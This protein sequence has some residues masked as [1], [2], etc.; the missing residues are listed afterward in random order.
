MED[1]VRAV[2]GR[3]GRGV[4]VLEYR[5]DEGHGRA[6]GEGGVPEAFAHRAVVFGDGPGDVAA[7]P[8]LVVELDS[9]GEGF[10]RGD[11]RLVEGTVLLPLALLV[12][13][14]REERLV[15]AGPCDR[16]LGRGRGGLLG[17]GRRCAREELAYGLFEVGERGGAGADGDGVEPVELGDGLGLGVERGV[18]LLPQVVLA[19]E[20]HV[21]AHARGVGADGHGVLAV[22]G[23][24]V[25]DQLAFGDV[26]VDALGLSADLANLVAGAPGH[27]VVR[28]GPL[29]VDLLLEDGVDLGG[30]AVPPELLG[31]EAG[32]VG[33]LTVDAGQDHRGRAGAAEAEVV[34]VGA[35]GVAR[36]PGRGRDDGGM[37]VRVQGEAD[38][39]VG[40]AYG[41][42]SPSV[43]GFG[44]RRPVRRRGARAAAR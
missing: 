32:V 12:E 33:L 3:E 43:M 37:V 21:P 35:G 23:M 14:G 40:G 42:G 38:V 30:E 7:V 41:I 22:V 9:Y 4:E 6:G 2:G 11:G 5:A 36:R 44:R 19:V 39:G 25:D 15:L 18:G 10:V 17:G 26:I 31:G 1:V 28:P 16:R 24:Q 29:G 13:Q 27:G 34:K 8:G 20:V